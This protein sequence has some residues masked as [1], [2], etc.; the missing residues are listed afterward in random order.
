M[1]NQ[2]RLVLGFY[3]LPEIEARRLKAHLEFPERE[4]SALDPCV[5]DGVAFTALLDGK[6]C[7]R[8]GIELD[9]LRAASAAA[10]GIEV[11]HGDAL[12]VYCAPESV[13]LL[14]LNPPYD[15]EVGSF[16]NRRFEELFLRHT[17][18]WLKATGVLV[19]VIPQ[20][21]LINCSTLLAEYFT[22]IRVYRLTAP[23]C[24]QYHQ[25]A[26]LAS[27]RANRHSQN[28]REYRTAVNHLNGLAGEDADI[29]ALAD[30]AQAY[31]RVPQS[32][33]VSLTNRGISLDVVEDL[34]ST[35]AAYK[36]TARLLLRQPSPLRGRP[37]TQLH[38][39]HV[40]LLAASGALNGVFGQGGDRHMANWSPAK[41]FHHSVEHETGGTVIS[42][43]WS[44]Y[45]PKL[46]LLYENGTTKVL[47]HSKLKR[48][49][50]DDG[51]TELP[52]KP[53]SGNAKSA[54]KPRRTVRRHI[55]LP[56]S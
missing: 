54:P 26:I 47:T 42:R 44:S 33:Q 31:Y 21:R 2:G 19:F 53:N 24:V 7:F 13:S 43:K 5:G 16:R 18:R 48:Q 8:H 11:V 10:K 35:S 6:T 50:E 51:Q 17:L 22:S 28:D 15:F 3:P 36:Q 39:G 38:G 20:R 4:F 23:E 29:P 37:I 12:E 14:Y 52:T 27:R 40:A 1:R 55:H 46:L 25:I 9:S 41:M 34:L 32:T 49:S 56:K 30:V 45:S